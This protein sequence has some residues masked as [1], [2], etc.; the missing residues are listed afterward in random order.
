MSLLIIQPFLK[1]VLKL[2]L[3]RI[4]L[5]ARN[6]PSDAEVLAVLQLGFEV[7]C[8]LGHKPIIE[9]LV[10]NLTEHVLG[11]SCFETSKCKLDLFHLGGL[12]FLAI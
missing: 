12:P 1:L 8:H 2:C 6:V 3:G 10:V 4:R 5:E 11:R 7:A 9:I